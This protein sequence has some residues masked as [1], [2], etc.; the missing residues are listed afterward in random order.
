[1]RRSVPEIGDP[2]GL[3]CATIE[4]LIAARRRLD[5][6]ADF[7]DWTAPA[8]ALAASDAEISIARARLIADELCSVVAKLQRRQ[9][10]QVPRHRDLISGKFARR[11]SN[12]AAPSSQEDPS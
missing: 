4:H 10:R 7:S 5:Q 8:A 9:R 6:A 11:P 1:M 3:L 12:G 2:A